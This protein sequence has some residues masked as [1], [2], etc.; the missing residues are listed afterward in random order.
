MSLAARISSLRL[1]RYL[2]TGALTLLPLWLT[3]I[4]FSFVFSLLSG[5]SVPWIAAIAQPLATAFPLAFGWLDAPW[6]QSAIAV[7]VTILL[8]YLV[9]WATNRVVGQRLIGAF[10]RG[11]GRIPLVQT[12]Y[13]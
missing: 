2:I 12:I 9:G 5:I 8:I 1:Q 11:I 7:F 6:V 4:V 13:G 10:D 3:W